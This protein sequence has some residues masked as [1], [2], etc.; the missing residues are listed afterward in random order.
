M[1]KRI[2]SL[3]SAGCILM[4]IA[5]CSPTEPSPPAVDSGV[6]EQDPSTIATNTATFKEIVTVNGIERGMGLMLEEEDGAMDEIPDREIDRAVE[7]IKPI[8]DKMLDGTPLSDDF[9][10]YRNILDAT[11]QQAYDQLRAALLNGEAKIAMTVPVKKSDIFNIYKMVIYDSP[12]I[13]WAEATKIRYWYN[14]AEIVTF[15]EPKYNDL[16]AD[17]PGNTAKFEAAAQEALADMWSLDTEL[18]KAK[19]AHDYL[20]HTITYSLDSAYNQTAYSALVNGE[21]VCAGYAHAFQYLM[22]QMGI[23]CSYILGYAMGGYHAW[24]LV[25]LDGDH[26]AMDVTWDDP[27]N[28]PPDY[29]TYEYF[30]L[31]DEKISFDHVRAELSDE[32]PAAEGILYNFETAFGE[33]FYG[34]DFDS[35]S[36]YLP[37]V[38]QPSEDT[39]DNPYLG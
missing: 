30:N 5:A 23:P 20:T 10:Y 22:Q 26:Y 34:T 33:G 32:L 11:Y 8:P 29:Y 35:I 3:L 28:A 38:I 2:I 17:I 7:P 25:M 37:E 6:I 27:L 39:S 31:S 9:Y 12:E 24:N 19:Y 21:T 1:K 14:Q 13:F 4:S 18:E 15:I 16:V 36:G